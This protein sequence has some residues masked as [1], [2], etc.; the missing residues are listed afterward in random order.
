MCVCVC[1]CVCQCDV[2]E[3]VPCHWPSKPPTL[4][5]CS[6][7][8]NRYIEIYPTNRPPPPRGGRG[9]GPLCVC[10]F[11]EGLEASGCKFHALLTFLLQ[12]VTGAIRVLFPSRRNV[13][14]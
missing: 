9:E 11:K 8:G 1:V 3:K 4:V 13:M 12:V 6:G 10:G 2:Y 14:A 7:V 5:C